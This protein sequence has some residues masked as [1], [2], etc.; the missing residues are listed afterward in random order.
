MWRGAGERRL[1]A[2]RREVVLRA[3]FVGEGAPSSAFRGGE[4][5]EHG[6]DEGWGA[7]IGAERPPGLPPARVAGQKGGGGRLA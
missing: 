2:V 6:G 5:V 4:G 3:G 7:G 1:S